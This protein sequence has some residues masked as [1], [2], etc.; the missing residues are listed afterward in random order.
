[1]TTK[2]P[3]PNTAKNAKDRT[4][5]SRVDRKRG[6]QMITELYFP[7]SPRTLEAWP[8]IWRYVNGR[9]TCDTEELLALAEAKL[10]AAPPLM[11]GRK[12]NS[13]LKAAQFSRL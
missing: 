6:A 11:G 7:I 8:I 3:D 1:M 5:P 12:A 9:A 13:P 2:C 10:N 4:R